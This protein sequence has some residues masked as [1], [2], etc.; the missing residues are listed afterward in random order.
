MQT[1]YIASFAT[2]SNCS[3]L[4]FLSISHVQGIAQLLI[5]LRVAEGR[6]Y[7]GDGHA[8]ANQTSTGMEFGRVTT[9]P[10]FDSEARVT[11]TTAMTY[12]SRSGTLTKKAS[13][14]TPLSSKAALKE[15]V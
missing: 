8:T 9:D 2:H 10:G 12:M 1:L 6:A 4:I 11:T 14:I 15:S 7:A 5:I 3:N 13:N